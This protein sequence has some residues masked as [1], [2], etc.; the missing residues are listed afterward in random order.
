[1]DSGEI[2]NITLQG[3][4]GF[5]CNYTGFTETNYGTIENCKNYL[6][7][8]LY[9]GIRAGI[10]GTNYGKIINTI[11]YANLTASYNQSISGI[12]NKNNGTL[13]NC[14]NYG[15]L[16]QQGGVDATCKVAGIALLIFQGSNIDGCKNYGELVAKNAGSLFG[17]ISGLT[18]TSDLSARNNLTIKNCSYLKNE[19]I[20]T[21]ISW[22]F[23]RYEL[24]GDKTV[25]NVLTDEQ[26]PTYFPNIQIPT[27]VSEIP[28][29]DKI[30][31]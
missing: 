17:S 22:L 26:I 27:A 12:V 7:A 6:S 1:M 24:Q 23:T 31:T 13:T 21:N 2:S 3:E 30:S 5:V 10:A 20:N 9:D 29:Q 16:T 14:I 19:I 4:E 15:T 11:N 25:E 28:E 18:T 8:N